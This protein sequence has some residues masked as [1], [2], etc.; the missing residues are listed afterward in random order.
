MARIRAGETA[1][2]WEAAGASWVLKFLQVFESKPA[3]VGAFACSLC[4]LLLLG[5]VYAERPDGTPKSALLASVIQPTISLADATSSVLAPSS[6]PTGLMIST[7]PV[8]SLESVPSLFGQQNSL[9]QP[10]SSLVQS[11]NFWLPGN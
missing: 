8:L 11:V 6:A 3:F 2:S 7:N 1:E 4:L 9:V 5:I 10:Q